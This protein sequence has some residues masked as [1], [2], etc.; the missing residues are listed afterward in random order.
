MNFRKPI[1]NLKAIV[2][3]E[4]T[5][6]VNAIL[7]ER[8]SQIAHPPNKIDKD[9]LLFLKTI[10]GDKDRELLRLITLPYQHFSANVHG[11]E[12]Y[13][14]GLT[15]DLEVEDAEGNKFYPGAYYV[16]VPAS[17]IIYAT[18]QQ[19]HLLPEKKPKACQR[20]P[21]HWALGTND[22]QSPLSYEIHTCLG[23]FA[24]MLP[25]VYR[26][27]DITGIF[28]AW[29]FYLSRWNNHSNLRGPHWG[30]INEIMGDPK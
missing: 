18:P 12:T 1:H 29:H 10:A 4:Y 16:F 2:D 24:N 3:P 13:L 28:Q 19:V 15:R 20:T 26:L 5:R 11:K 7:K 30:E 25:S 8:I 17:S 9:M 21:H 6:A 14:V 27:M 23:G 22:K